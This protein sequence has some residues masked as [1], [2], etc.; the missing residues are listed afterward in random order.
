[1]K[2]WGPKGE[3]HSDA[4]AAAQVAVVDSQQGRSA[5]KAIERVC[6]GEV[7]FV[8]VQHAAAANCLWVNRALVHRAEP[9]YA[10][11]VLTILAASDAASTHALTA[12]ELQKV[13]GLLTCSSVLLER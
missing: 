9:E 6:P 2:G 3:A 1:M 13:D 10:N 11:D 8:M 4:V 5:A 12:G 7:A